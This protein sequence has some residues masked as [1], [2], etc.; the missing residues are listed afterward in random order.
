MIE[1]DKRELQKTF[2]QKYQIV[3]DM[4]KTNVSPSG[5]QCKALQP[6][7][8]LFKIYLCFQVSIR[9]DPDKNLV[10]ILHSLV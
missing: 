7:H 1:E 5:Y 2:E 8:L 9:G 4:M 10:G 3:D 6:R